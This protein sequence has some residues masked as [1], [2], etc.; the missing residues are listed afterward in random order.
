MALYEAKSGSIEKARQLISQ[1]LAIAPKEP[2]VLTDAVE[3]YTL[4]GER[5]MALDYLKN[6]VQSGYPRFELEANPELASLRSDP[7][8]REMMAKAV[9]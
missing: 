8:Y 9:P 1:A 6:A 2:D 3:V 5:Q 4:A 7:R